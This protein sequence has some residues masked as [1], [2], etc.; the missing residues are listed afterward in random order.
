MVLVIFQQKSDRDGGVIEP[1]DNVNG[2]TIIVIRLL[3]IS[4]PPGVAGGF[5]LIIKYMYSRGSLVQCGIEYTYIM[6]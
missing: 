5:F 1:A 3:F 6:V 4:Y 2:V